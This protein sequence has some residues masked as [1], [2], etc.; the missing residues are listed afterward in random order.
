[1]RI[2]G[3][4]R[5]PGSRLGHALG[6]LEARGHT[7]HRARGL[8][9][10]VGVRA[11]VVVGDG[12]QPLR[13]ALAGGLAGARVMAL[14]L[15][16]DDVA[17][18]RSPARWAWHSLYTAA[19]VE[20]AEAAAFAADPRGLERQRIG[21]WPAVPAAEAAEAAHLDT[22]V[23]E[24]ACERA[25]AR[26]Q[27]RASRPAVFLD[28]DDTLIPDPGDLSHP[29][30]VELLPGVGRA[31]RN[32]AEADY[33]LVVISNQ[34]GIARGRFTEAQVHAIMARMRER[35]R[36]HGVELAAIYFCPHLP[37]AGCPCRKPR[38]G[39]LERA[40]DDLDLSLAGSVMIGDKRIDAAA[41][42]NAGGR[43]I[44]VRTGDPREEQGI[45]G[46][47]PPPDLVCD[48]LRAAVEWLL[49]PPG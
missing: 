40:A 26:H 8:R 3:I 36:D 34:S 46:G 42:R 28:R 17:R 4:G 12:D 10:L 48:D 11:D 23:L 35:L 6:G 20:D 19:L 2:L 43:G 7:V 16:H 32:L 33:P 24:R 31:L 30:T 49:G 22:E 5:R 47:V 18:W 14:D 25:L 27:G 1:V 45:P 44:L 41:G 38:P 21:L 37:D 39:L 9:A 15:R 29:G 13:T